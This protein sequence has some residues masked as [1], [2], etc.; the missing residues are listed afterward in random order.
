VDLALLA[1]SIGV[2]VVAAHS[3]LAYRTGRRAVTPD[4]RLASGHAV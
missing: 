3:F 1:L 4:R 2:I